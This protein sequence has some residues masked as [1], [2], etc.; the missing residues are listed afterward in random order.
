M[1]HFDY[2]QPTELKFGSGRFSEMGDLASRYGRRALLVTTDTGSPAL[3][4]RFE[5]AR[6]ILTDA[7]MEVS[8]YNGV[9]ENPTV[10]SVSKGA[11]QAIDF[12]ADVVIGIGGG[13]SMDSAKAISVEATHEGTCWD[14]L[15]YKEQPQKE[16]LLS[17]ITIPTTSGTGSQTSKVAVVTNSR[18]RNKSALVNPNLFPTVAIID[19]KL[20]V[21]TPAFVTATTGFDVF[22]HAFESSIHPDA[23]AY[24]DLLAW[25][26]LEMVVKYLP[27]A[28][29]EPNNMEA[30]EKMAWADTMAG[31]CIANAGVTL[32]HGMAMAIGGMYPQVAHAQ[33]LA[34]VYPAF[35]DFTREWAAES[36]ARLARLLNPNLQ[37]ASDKEAGSQSKQE[38]EQFLQKIGLYKRLRDIDMPEEEIKALADQSMVLPDYKGNPRVASREEMMELVK[39]SY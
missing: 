29:E 35:A 39:A 25:S 17:I 15:Y 3:A 10:E 6:K 5:R 16:K 9:M 20:V 14:Y 13:S 32:P 34:I 18:E 11:R 26:A 12:G 8:H 24:L 31:M 38:V 21:T 30:R 23:G 37:K 4:K 19:P 2:F 27:T 7:G 28:I 36:F 1:K 33:A 22:C